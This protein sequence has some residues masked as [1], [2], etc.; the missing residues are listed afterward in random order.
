MNTVLKCACRPLI[1]FR[2]HFYLLLLT[3]YFVLTQR[4]GETRI[5]SPFEGDRKLTGTLHIIKSQQEV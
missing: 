2:P 1:I 4:V 5:L 3:P